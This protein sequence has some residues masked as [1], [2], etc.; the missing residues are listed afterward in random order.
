L[1]TLPLL[2]SIDI[3]DKVLKNY[4][5]PA[6]RSA[7]E[8]ELKKLIDKYKYT[9][10]FYEGYVDYGGT[11]DPNT[12][13][14]FRR[15]L[16]D[17]NDSIYQIVDRLGLWSWSNVTEMLIMLFYYISLSISLLLFVFRYSTARTFFL[18]LLVGTLLFILTVLFFASTGG[19]SGTT[20]FVV[21]LVYYLLFAVCA[22]PV[23]SA[24][25]RSAVQ[26]IA[27]NLF[28]LFT[29]FI[30]LIITGL[31]YT[32]IRE[33]Y[34]NSAINDPDRIIYKE[35]TKNEELHFYLSQIGG[36]ILLLLA[37]Q[38]LFGKLYRRWFAAAEQ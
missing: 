24:K 35:L 23:M 38:F 5:P 20:P 1:T 26:G 29:P 31:I 13:I 11:D 7:K 30:P 33:N 4:Q 34:Y 36:F 17:V 19:S 22:I 6:D 28:V 18:S 12:R 37:I 27:L 32:S 14:R 2:S 16:N 9:R 21:L 8:K 3:F 10:T 15:G 25:I